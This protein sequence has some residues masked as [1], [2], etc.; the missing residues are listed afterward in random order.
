MSDTGQTTSEPRAES[1]LGARLVSCY[2]SADPRWLGV[3]RIYFG[4]ILCADLLRRW[5]EAR[6]Y[7]TNDGFLPNHFSL[8]RPMG[9]K[10]FSLY[11][12]FSTLNEIHVV[13]TLTAIV[14]LAY[15]IGYK[16]KLAQILA[17]L[18]ITSLDSRNL[19]V[20]NGGDVVVNLLAV[21]TMFMPLGRRFSVDAV[22]AS[23]RAVKETTSAELNDRTRPQPDEEPF[24][25][26]IV[27]LLLVQLAVIYFFNTVHKNGVGWREGTAIHY[28]LEQDRIVT[29]VGI[30]IR[31]NVP[32][33]VTKL[34][35]Y[36]TLVVEG[37]LPL[38]ILSPFFHRRYALLFAVG[39]HGGI[40]LMS[41]L[42]P[43]S[44]VMVAF[45]VMLLGPSEWTA[46]TRWFR[47]ESR[48]KTVIYDA[49]CGI[50]LWLSRLAK[51]LDPFERLTFLANDEVERFPSG[52]SP[53]LVE[54]TLVVVDAKGR[55]YTQEQA[56]RA[57]LFA[58]PFGFLLGVWLLVPGIKQLAR[59]AYDKVAENRTRLSVACGLDA[60]GLVQRAPEQDE[61]EEASKPPRTLRGDVRHG[62][63]LAREVAVALIGAV[64]ITQIAIDNSWV[65]ARI[66]VRRAEWM[67]EIVD[68]FRLLQGWSMFAPE[69][70]Y[71]D[72]RL[73]VDARTKDGRKLD[74]FTGK[75]PDFS[76]DTRTG[77]GHEQFWCDYNNKIRFGWFTQHRQFLREYLKRWHEF[78]GKP[79]DQL[80]AFD[81]W[82][83]ED[84]SPPPGERKT[85]PLPPSKLVSWGI[86]RDSG[87]TE[88]LAKTRKPSTP[89]GDAAKGGKP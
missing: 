65:R 63:G 23:M 40:A 84:R 41:R 43:F 38:L 35:T 77:W 7:Y 88:L 54:R 61:G 75:E 72:G 68:R 9:D 79:E 58:L 48:R 53:E 62:L 12:P 55:V 89:A 67:G 29:R 16:T 52:A 6:E 32:F 1:R 57:A 81:V 73:V 37:T 70:P 46:F 82:W 26:L 13:F 51:R 44:Y 76:T 69:P 24:V 45:F 71:E 15:T 28:F 3:F 36:G 47:R 4:L 31:E 87:A 86:V 56:V 59:F 78:T 42:G 60:C 80:V 64:F 66:K 21:L 2:L 10:L 18:L 8:F 25:S 14:F 33:S 34:F 30:W 50:C 19:F 39:L 27:L 20:E 74:P 11:H 83:V 5:V 17:A 85:T 49:D 22:I